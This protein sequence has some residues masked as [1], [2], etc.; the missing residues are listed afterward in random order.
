MRTVIYVFLN[1]FF[2]IKILTQRNIRRK[3]CIAEGPLYL[4][5][6]ITFFGVYADASV[7][8]P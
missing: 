1:V 5:F 7:R 6:V 8:K 4:K 2:P 3:V